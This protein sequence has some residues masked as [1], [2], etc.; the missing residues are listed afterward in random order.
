MHG[1]IFSGNAFAA[2][3]ISDLPIEEA[4]AAWGGDTVIWVNFPETVFWLRPPIPPAGGAV[5][6]L[7]LWR[8]LGSISLWGRIGRTRESKGGVD[9][10]WRAKAQNALP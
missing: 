4:R 5:R 6:G 7:K 10:H 9:P 8:M 1:R 3:P 2:P